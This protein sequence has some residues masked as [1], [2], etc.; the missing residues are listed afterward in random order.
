MAAIR[1]KKS[2]MIFV[3][4]SDTTLIGMNVAK[5]SRAFLE[6][7]DEISVPSPVVR[8]SVYLF[9]LFERVHRFPT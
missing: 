5:A 6:S 7:A 8:Q 9:L 2:K 4:A 3:R 1:S